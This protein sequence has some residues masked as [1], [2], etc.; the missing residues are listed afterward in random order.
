MLL[1]YSQS[2]RVNVGKSGAFIRE[3]RIEGSANKRVSPISQRIIHI[4]FQPFYFYIFALTVKP[5][6]LN[7]PGL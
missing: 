5:P 2:I 3:K 1:A 6:R 7:E 4:R